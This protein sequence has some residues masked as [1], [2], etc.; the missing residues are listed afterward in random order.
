M[1]KTK[2]PSQPIV[3]IRDYIAAKG[4]GGDERSIRQC[5]QDI[6]RAE[7]SDIRNRLLSMPDFYSMSECRDLIFHTQEHRY[8]LLQLQ[9]ILDELRLEFLGFE[10]FTHTA[11]QHYA[12]LFANDKTQTNLANWHQLEQQNP[13][14][15]FGMYQMWLSPRN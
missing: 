3:K 9:Q 6:M 1:L 12:K 5:R 2:P 13:S 8:N 11:M 7:P 4:Y 14:L 10:H 15:F